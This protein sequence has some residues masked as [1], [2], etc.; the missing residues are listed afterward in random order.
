MNSAPWL[1]V[2]PNE[3]S[4]DDLPYGV[5][6]TGGNRHLGVALGQSVFDVHRAAS[7]GLFRDVV[8]PEVLTAGSLNPL[9]ELGP[10][11]WTD[12]RDRIRHLL[13]SPRSSGEHQV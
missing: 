9:L 12:V 8:S 11:E 3:P 6:S 1:E 10:E 13:T 5:F 2:G 4:L 7:V